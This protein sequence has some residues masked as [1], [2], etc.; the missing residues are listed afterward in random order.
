MTE[1]AT[2]KQL[3]GPTPVDS[4][5]DGSITV[6]EL[7][8]REFDFVWRLLRRLGLS[9]AD[10]DDAAQEVFIVAA[11]RVSDIA[12]GRQRSFLTG[13]AL[14]VAATQRRAWARR[15]EALEPNL[16]THRSAGPDPE[17]MA[18][19]RRRLALLDQILADIDWELRVPFILFELEEL[20]APQVAELLGIPPGTVASRVRRAREL[21]RQAARRARARMEGVP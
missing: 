18:L 14:N 9:A 7:V 12:P 21:F 2:A 20:T 4:G 15:R 1:G 10:A 11:R 17:A 19:E 3:V 6:S 8:A 16:E 13:T 5:M